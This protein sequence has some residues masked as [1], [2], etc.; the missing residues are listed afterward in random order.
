M[1]SLWF[2]SSFWLPSVLVS[3]VLCLF[4]PL[5]PLWWSSFLGLVSPSSSV[6]SLLSLLLRRFV[7]LSPVRIGLNLGR[8]HSAR[9][10]LFLRR[11]YAFVFIYRIL[12]YGALSSSVPLSLVLFVGCLPISLIRAFHFSHCFLRVRFFG[13]FYSSPRS[14]VI[15]GCRF[16]WSF[17]LFLCFALP[18]SPAPSSPFK[19]TTREERDRH[20]VVPSLL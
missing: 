13:R 11:A 5:F 7:R 4:L 9:S 17:L 12:R 10:S 2:S 19:T 1:L 16:P 14:P 20:S 15:C 6:L 18:S 3:V 8:S